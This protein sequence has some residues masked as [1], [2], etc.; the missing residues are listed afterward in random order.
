MQANACFAIR[1][2]DRIAG[3][4]ER[5][6]MMWISHVFM[7]PMM[8]GMSSTDLLGYAAATC[9]TVSFLPQ[10]IK[11]LREDTHSLS[12]GMYL[13]FTIGVCLWGLYGYAKHDMAMIVANAITA[14]FCLAILAAKLR[15]DVFLRRS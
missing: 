12:L 7:G 5:R 1:V 3:M 13:I 10:A 15:N 8:F 4:R 9:T 2:P 11:A 14:A 6:R